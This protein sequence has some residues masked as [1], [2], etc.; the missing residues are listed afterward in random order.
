MLIYAYFTDA[1]SGEKIIIEY[2]QEEEPVN[3]HYLLFTYLKT[4]IVIGLTLRQ[5]IEEK[6]F[7]VLANMILGIYRPLQRYSGV[8][9]MFEC[10]SCDRSRLSRLR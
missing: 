2:R 1:H 3:N 10:V 9:N 5:L 8:A 7:R 4:Q 6:L